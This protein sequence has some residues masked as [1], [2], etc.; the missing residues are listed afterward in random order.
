MNRIFSLLIAFFL[1]ASAVVI[2]L[3]ATGLLSFSSQGKSNSSSVVVGAPQIGGDFTLTNHRGESVTNKDFEGKFMLIFF[4]YTFCPDVCP[5]EMQTISLAMEEL[6]DDA[7]NVIPVFISVD[8]KRD[9]VEV[10]ADFVDAFH[11]SLVGL[12]GTEK[13]ISEVKQKYRVYSQ[14]ADDEDP[15]YYMVDHTSFTYLMGRDGELVTVFS[16]GTSADAMA[17]KIAENL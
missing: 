11:P 13:Q 4:G 17:D 12:T 10:M 2:G 5:T 16:Y 1:L 7:E 14:K 3:W 8:P 15:D 6:G 9:T